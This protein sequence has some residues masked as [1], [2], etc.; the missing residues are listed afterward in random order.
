VLEEADLS[1][2]IVTSEVRFDSEYLLRIGPYKRDL[3]SNLTRKEPLQK[4]TL[5]PIGR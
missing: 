5:V 3:A 4:I 2:A 1:F